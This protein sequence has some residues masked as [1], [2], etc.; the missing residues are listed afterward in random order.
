MSKITIKQAV[1]LANI[2]HTFTQSLK[3][4]SRKHSLNYKQTIIQVV[5]SIIEVEDVSSNANQ[6]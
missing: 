1:E 5:A 4:F 6:N 3:A 2:T